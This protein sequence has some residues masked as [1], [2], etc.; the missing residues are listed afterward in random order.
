MSETV[1]K[2]RRSR[3]PT[4]RW[5]LSDD[6]SIVK[7]VKGR[8][9]ET[10]SL[11]GDLSDKLYHAAAVE[12]VIALL[13]RGASFA[14]IVDGTGF[15]DRTAPVAKVKAVRVPRAP[16]APRAPKIAAPP[17]VKE[18]DLAIIAV[19]KSSLLNEAL[20]D[21][22]TL[23]LAKVAELESNATTFVQGLSKEAKSLLSKTLAVKLERA[24]I[25]GNAV[26]LD[27]ILAAN[28]TADADAPIACAAD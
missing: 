14:S 16:R 20:A 22:V 10:F 5:D 11:G 27:D 25:R 21:G 1:T 15:P 3:G 26:S 28:V 9:D 6:G 17:K 4:V 19:Q 12:G 18:T 24:K 8:E 2:K 7:H 23:D 13:S